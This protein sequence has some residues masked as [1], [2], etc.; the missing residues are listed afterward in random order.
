MFDLLNK[1]LS[2]MDKRGYMYACC[3]APLNGAVSSG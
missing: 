1:V 3:N 2:F